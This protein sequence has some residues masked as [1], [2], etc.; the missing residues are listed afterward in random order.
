MHLVA[1]F[2]FLTVGLCLSALVK[3]YQRVAPCL[4]LAY[5]TVSSGWPGKHLNMIAYRPSAGIYLL[6]GM[7]VVEPQAVLL[8]TPCVSYSG[9]QSQHCPSTDADVSSLMCA[10]G[11]FSFSWSVL[12]SIPGAFPPLVFSILQ[13]P[14]LA[15]PLRSLHPQLLSHQS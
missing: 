4:P 9:K 3:A 12:A 15:L 7:A 11:H 10:P 8:G 14:G 2:S 6:F 13:S 5:I 1:C